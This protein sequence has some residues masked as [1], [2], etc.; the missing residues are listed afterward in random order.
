MALTGSAARGNARADSDLD[1][2]VLGAR[3]GRITVNRSGTSITLLCQRFD[4]ATTLDNL[5]FY[6]VDDLIVLRD[7]SGAFDRLKR[8]WNRRRPA[9]HRRIETATEEQ[10]VW[11]LER[12]SRGSL[13]HRAAFLRLACWRMACLFVFLK[14]GWRVPRL[15]LLAEELPAASSRRLDAVL[16][17]PSA[18]VCRR[19]ARQMPRAVRE[20]E[21]MLARD[22]K[23]VRLEVPE[24]IAAKAGSAPKE[25]AFLAR[26]ELVLEL[27]PVVF[28]RYG[29][30]DLKGVELL[31]RAPT[32]RAVLLGLEPKASEKTVQALQQHARALAKG[33][34]LG[35]RS[36]LE[37]FLKP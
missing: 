29:V 23:A 34:G 14:R 30:T 7:P 11:E 2:W 3:S 8:I 17:L 24:S 25:A 36:A 19:F 22:G 20:L 28:A 6:E 15:H 10:L 26:R 18:A 12:G 1:L 4:E 9:I 35:Q 37:W 32:A 16:G 33:L 5:C 13:L 27:L 21:A 31:D